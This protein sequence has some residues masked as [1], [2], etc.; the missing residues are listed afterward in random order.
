MS[1]ERLELTLIRHADGRANWTPMFSVSPDGGT[2]SFAFAGIARLR[3][4]SVVGSCQGESGVPLRFVVT[5]LDGALP[6]H[7]PA[8]AGGNPEVANQS[9]AFALHSASI[10]DLAAGGDWARCASQADGR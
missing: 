4:G 2:A 3:I 5:V 6:L 8:T 9:F 10:A 7:D 1:G